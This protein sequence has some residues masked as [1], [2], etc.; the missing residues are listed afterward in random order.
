MKG[1]IALFPVKAK[2]REKAALWI[3]KLDGSPLTESD[4]EELRAWLSEDIRHR[5][6]LLQLASTFDDTD[7]LTDLSELF[8]L[9][10]DIRKDTRQRRNWFGNLSMPVAAMAS[11]L[12]VLTISVYFLFDINQ[13][14]SAKNHKST[15]LVYQTAIG[16]QQ[17]HTLVDGSVILLNTN[18]R[19]EV[20]FTTSA[21]AVRLLFGEVNFDVAKNSAMP[22]V[23]YTNMGSIRAVGT[24]FSVRIF[25]EQ[26]DVTVTE[27]R[28]K[29]LELEEPA[30]Q[31]KSV[32]VA[33]IPANEE[34]MSLDAGQIG[35]FSKKSHT[36]KNITSSEITQ[37]LSW[38][39]GVLV[40][41]GEMLSEAVKEIS[42]YTDKEII[43]TDEELSRTRVGGYF[44][45]NDIDATLKT[46]EDNFNIEV[47]RV[48]PDRI[49]LSTKEKVKA[50]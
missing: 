36:S 1:N 19:I 27:G 18:S 5:N 4:A 49:L 41:E 40:F 50:Y 35:Q 13:S 24:T 45:S 28:V 37:M 11:G 38:Q 2:I 44:K 17:S 26:V 16:E 33:T 42:R 9:Q 34:I 43:I 31:K 29:V 25:E 3:A 6:I 12:I 10:K 32:S 20:D 15:G 14:T 8:P 7:V 21:R 48:T 46:L 39:R 30:L 22:F 47:D 23:V